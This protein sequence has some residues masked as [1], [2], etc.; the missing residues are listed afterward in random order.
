M[1][2]SQIDYKEMDTSLHFIKQSELYLHSIPIRK[3]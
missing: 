1:I 3:G 2:D